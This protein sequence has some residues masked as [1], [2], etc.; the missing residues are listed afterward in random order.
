MLSRPSS[1]A[2]SARHSTHSAS[3]V[4]SRTVQPK[5]QQQSDDQQPQQQQQQQQTPSTQQ[6]KSSYSAKC[7][8]STKIEEI[9][10]K[11]GGIDIWFYFVY[12]NPRLQVN[13][14]HPINR[15]KIMINN[16]RVLIIE[17]T[18]DQQ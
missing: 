10:A 9:L 1:P 15:M 7:E 18:Q 12:S 5:S 2:T 11:Y 14:S 17:P 8:Q 4:T 13:Y 3:S 16:N 6:V